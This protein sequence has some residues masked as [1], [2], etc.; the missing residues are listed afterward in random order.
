MWHSVWAHHSR[1]FAHTIFPMAAGYLTV[2]DQR[3]ESSGVRTPN[4]VGV[5]IP[6]DNVKQ[7]RPCYPRRAKPQSGKSMC[8]DL[9]PMHGVLA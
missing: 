4:K 3:G 1:S 7:Q 6:K 5:E 8:N 9:S 2:G